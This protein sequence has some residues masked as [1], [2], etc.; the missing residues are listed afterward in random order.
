LKNGGAALLGR[1]PLGKTSQPQSCRAATQILAPPA[2][3]VNTTAAITG[4]PSASASGPVLF[5][6]LDVHTGSTEV[7]RYGKIGGTHDDVVRKGVR[8]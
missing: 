8:P 5:T 4:T 1:L 6:G 7:R 2:A 3:S